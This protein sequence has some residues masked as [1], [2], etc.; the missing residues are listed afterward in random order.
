MRT[1]KDDGLAAVFRFERDN[2]RGRMAFKCGCGE[3][4]NMFVSLEERKSSAEGRCP[5][6]AAIHQYAVRKE[7][8]AEGG[9]PGSGKR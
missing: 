3:S 9:K 1:G 4:V 8:S 7:L 5:Q 6:C 2:G